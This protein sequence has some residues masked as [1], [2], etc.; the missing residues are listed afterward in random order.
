MK[1]SLLILLAAVFVFTVS[2][3]DEDV[4]AEEVSLSEDSIT[5][6]EGDIQE[7]EASV[8]PDDADQ[9]VVWESM[10]EDV[11]LVNQDGEVYGEAPGYTVIRVTSA[12]DATVTAYLSVE[13]LAEPDYVA[14]DDPDVNMFTG[15]TRAIDW[16]VE[17]RD[18]D[19]PNKWSIDDLE[20][21]SLDGD[22]VTV[23]DKGVLEAQA[24][25]L[26]EV[27]V[28]AGSQFT[29]VEVF[30][31]DTETTLMDELTPEDVVRDDMA[32]PGSIT[33]GPWN[34]SVDWSSSDDDVITD[35]GEVSRPDAEDGD[36]GVTLT[37]EAEG[38]PHDFTFEY[39]VTVEADMKLDEVIAAE[40]GDDV[41][42]TGIVTGFSDHSTIYIEDAYGAFVIYDR[43]ED[44]IDDLNIGDYVYV[45]GERDV[46][47]GLEQIG[48]LDALDV[49]ESDVD[50][51]DSVDYPY[52]EAAADEDFDA[53][54][55]Q[56][57]RVNIP[58]LLIVDKGEDQFGNIDMDLYDPETGFEI[59]I[60]Y[61]DRLADSDDDADHLWGFEVGDTVNIVD[62]HLGWFHGPQ[63]AYSSED[64]VVECEDPIDEA[65]FIKYSVDPVWKAELGEAIADG[66]DNVELPDTIDTPFGELDVAWDAPELDNNNNGEDN[67]IDENGDI[68][69]PHPG[70]EDGEAMLEAT[71]TDDNDLEEE[72]TLSFDVPAITYEEILDAYMYEEEPT[73]ITETPVELPDEYE[74]DDY[75]YKGY[76][77]ENWELDIAWSFSAPEFEYGD[78]VIFEAVATFTDDN[79]FERDVTFEFEM[80]PVFAEPVFE[81]HIED[82]ENFDEPGTSYEDGTFTG[83]EDIEWTYED[84]RGDQ[85][86]NILTLRDD[87]DGKL[88]ATIDGGIDYFSIEYTNTFS[89]PAGIEVYIDDDLVG[90]GEEVEDEWGTLEIEDLETEGTFDIR[91]ETTNGQTNLR[92]LMWLPYEVD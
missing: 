34:F 80:D 36:A 53:L 38:G 6:V 73:Q 10:N 47:N 3:C 60:R 58:R 89:S 51:P 27:E 45:E 87:G 83:V 32:L 11:A 54:P 62:M 46:W 72:V 42:T 91:I 23:D 50:L 81:G 56:A 19:L 16:E 37:A 57:H 77:V 92:N 24:P 68:E 75:D 20:F 61:D 9:E 29:Y 85:G 15:E 13:V 64:Q 76:T 82:F 22:I 66:A 59:S 84:A 70:E 78:D 4:L 43:D 39:P 18:T 35:D 12:E 49:L 40:D 41:M 44:Y 31:N 17:L 79:D 1:K 5:L 52:A 28:R 63:L 33:L 55:Y 88:S 21:T 69:R 71:I 65:E 2:A 74:I 86:D 25:G 67:L 90:T 48:S 26:V 8:E 7:I 14:V 30:V